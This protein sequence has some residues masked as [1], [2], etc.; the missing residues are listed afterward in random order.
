V[1]DLGKLAIPI[2]T[3]EEL[4]EVL[5]REKFDKYFIN[6][7]ERFVFVN[8]I[9]SNSVLFNAKISVSDCRDPKDNKFLELAVASDASC[10][11]TRDKDLLV[12]HPF[13]GISILNA[14]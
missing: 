11:V 13:R 8:K 4:M 9:E 10:I 6:A 1:I 12:L 2:N 14:A 5:F 3:T 7:E